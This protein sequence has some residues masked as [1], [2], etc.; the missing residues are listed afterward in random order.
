MSC[1]SL[2]DGEYIKGKKNGKGKM[3]WNDGSVYEGEY[4][5]DL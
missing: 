5:D 1:N 2:F 3:V 4:K